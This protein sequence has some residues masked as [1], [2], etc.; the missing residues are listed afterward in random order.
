MKE[1]CDLI[2]DWFG[3]TYASYL[4]LPRVLMQEMPAKWQEKMVIL[5]NEAQDTWEHDDN[6]T[7]QLKDKKGRFKKDPLADYRHPDW[8]AV[9]AA[10]KPEIK[11]SERNG[12]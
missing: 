12:R 9:N 5:L 7:V 11:N 2:H 1:R 3:L 6:Y 4:V 10:R 8:D